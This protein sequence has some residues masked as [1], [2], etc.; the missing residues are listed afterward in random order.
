MCEIAISNKP[1]LAARLQT[2]NRVRNF[3]FVLH[4]LAQATA[5]PNS[6]LDCKHA[7]IHAPETKRDNAE[8]IDA[9]DADAA[10]SG[11]GSSS[12]PLRHAG[13]HYSRRVYDISRRRLALASH[14]EAQKR[15]SPARAHHL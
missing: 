10:H 4:K 3:R 1:T 12:G 2:H 6:A 7:R 5:D 15:C 14:C 9:G 13:H 11:K 8:S